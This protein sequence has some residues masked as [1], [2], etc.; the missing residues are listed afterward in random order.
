M[1]E[2][3]LDKITVKEVV[4][5]CGVNRQTFYYHFRDIYDLLDWMFAHDGEQFAKRYAPAQ[6]DDDGQQIIGALCR[7]L[8]EHKDLTVNI[9]HSLGRERLD[10][11]LCK[12]L[13]K[14]LYRNIKARGDVLGVPED[15]CVLLASFYKH[16]FA[17]IVLDWIQEGMHGDIDDIVVRFRPILDGTFDAALRKMANPR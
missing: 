4:Q 10:R 15:K 1:G 17:G 6:M 7:S 14:L 13:Y 2:K 12:E 11:Y 16:A 5:R 8:Q 3:T 9:Y